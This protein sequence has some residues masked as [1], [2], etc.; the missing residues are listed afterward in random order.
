MRAAKQSYRVIG[1]GSNLL[2]ADSGFSD[3]VIKL[4]RGFRCYSPVSGQAACFDVSGAM[5]L[6]T[7]SRELSD[8][9]YS[10]LEFAGGIPAVLGGAITMN[11]GAHGGEMSDI[12][13][14]VEILTV[15]GTK[16]HLFP[17]DCGFQ[18]RYC[19]LPQGSVVVAARIKLSE[20]DP[21]KTKELRFKNLEY[22]KATQPLSLP[23]SGSVF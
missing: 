3:W 13:S 21:Q 5:P 20:S 2:I 6:M 17:K 18:Y 14:E 23:S 16:E 7:L 10:G 22:R 19:N 8:Q 12:V 11:A 4:D 15:D 1:A 9:G